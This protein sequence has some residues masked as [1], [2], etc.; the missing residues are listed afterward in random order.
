MGRESKMET[1]ESIAMFFIGF[2]IGMFFVTVVVLVS[3]EPIILSQET[4]DD[5][6]KNLT[7]NETT[8]ATSDQGRLTCKLPSYDATQNIIIERNNE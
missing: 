7:G 3:I 2:I 1:G 6:C 8:V 5:V 4:A